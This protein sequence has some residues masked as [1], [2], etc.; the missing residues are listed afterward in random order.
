MKNDA[1]VKNVLTED[2]LPE[3]SLDA[4]HC[5]E[6]VT[7]I[8]LEDLRE[9]LGMGSWAVRIA[10]NELFGGVIIQQQPG[11][12]NRKHFH[13]DADENWVILDGEGGW[14]I[15]GIG[16]QKVRKHDIIVVPQGVLHHIKCVGENPGV[17]YAITRPDVNHVYP[18]EEDECKV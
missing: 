15:D 9:K 1:N 17:R 16:T 7:T 5:Y 3:D 4:F 12:G 6:N 14:W 2:G 18:N 11:E 8:N 13:P 10:Y